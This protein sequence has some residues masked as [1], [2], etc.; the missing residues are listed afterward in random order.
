MGTADT[1]TCGTYLPQFACSH[2]FVVRFDFPATARSGMSHP[3]SHRVNQ[4]KEPCTYSAGSQ[5]HPVMRR[6]WHRTHPVHEAVE[7]GE[8]QCTRSGV[9]GNE[10][11][12]C[13]MWCACTCVRVCACTCVRVCVRACAREVERWE[14][15]ACPAA[16]RD[17]T[18]LSGTA[19]T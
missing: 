9:Q 2:R 8:Y 7:R 18:H 1:S 10:C 15:R 3:W 12:L 17:R 11:S 4:R 16:D 13:G 14:R 19:V 6:V 5:A